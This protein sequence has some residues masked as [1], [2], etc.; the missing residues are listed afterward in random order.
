MHRPPDSSRCDQRTVL[1]EQVQINRDIK[2]L[3]ENQAIHAQIS[4]N[5][6]IITGPLSM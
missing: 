5:V 1:G 3:S 2:N 6:L 4:Y